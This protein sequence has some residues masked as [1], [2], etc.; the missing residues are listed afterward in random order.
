MR[1]PA[2]I[3]RAETEADRA[4]VYEVVRQSFEQDDESRL[5]DALRDEGYARVSLV[6]VDDDR[7]VGHILFS[8]I[9]IVSPAANTP[10]LALAPMAV[11]PERQRQGIG[12]RLIGEGLEACRAAGHAIVLVL[13]HRDYYPRFGFSRDLARPLESEYQGDSF[14]AIELVPDALDGVSGRVVYPPPFGGF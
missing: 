1:P 4:A 13:G 9:E 12:S 3:V 10:A 11:V 7:V 5:V 8:A 14:M 2:V 6:A